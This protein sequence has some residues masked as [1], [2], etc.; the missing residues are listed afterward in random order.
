MGRGYKGWFIN[1]GNGPTHRS[2][3]SYSAPPLGTTLFLKIQSVS[4]TQRCICNNN[5]LIVK[6]SANR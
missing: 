3:A 6:M 5:G 2:K 1:Q 4:E